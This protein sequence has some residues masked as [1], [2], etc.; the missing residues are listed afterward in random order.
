M[1]SINCCKMCVSQI[2]LVE[3]RFRFQCRHGFQN[4]LTR[5]WFQLQHV[6]QLVILVHLR[7]ENM[8]MISK[9]DLRV[10]FEVYVHRQD[11]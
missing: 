11:S 9:Q 2:V 4:S 5:K 8:E 1:G 7:R 10:F 6:F 3:S